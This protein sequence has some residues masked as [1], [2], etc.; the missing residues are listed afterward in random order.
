MSSY[1]VSQT[2]VKNFLNL[3]SMNDQEGISFAYATDEKV[4][5]KLIPKPLKLVAPIVCGYVVQRGKPSFG[6]P[7]L[8]QTLFALVSYQ[9]KMVGSYPLTLLLHGPG[10]ESGLVAGREGAGIPKK[11]ADRIELRRNDNQATASVDRHGKTLLTV[12]WEAGD[13]NDPSILK[14]FGSQFALNKPSEM[15]S[16]FFTYDLNQ[17]DHGANHFTNVELVA[18]QMQSLADRVEP[19]KLKIKVDSTEDDPF[20]ELPVLKPLGA[21]WYHFATSTMVKTLHLEKVDAEKTAPYLITGRYDRSM[22]NPLATTY[23]I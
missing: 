10:A 19:G 12:D 15:N 11:L 3:P 20:G 22:M 6:G 7:Y 13:V 8:E 5:A 4:L 17:D 23:I 9:D 18:T 2:D 1:V 16:F 14:T 21:M